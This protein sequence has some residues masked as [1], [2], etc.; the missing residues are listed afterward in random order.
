MALTRKSTRLSLALCLH[1]FNDL[2]SSDVRPANEPPV[3]WRCQSMRTIRK[4]GSH[5]LSILRLS[6]IFSPSSVHAG[7][8]KLSLAASPLTAMTFAPVAVLPILTM[9]I[10]FFAG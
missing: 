5:V 6:A 9:R 3:F 8:V 2:S 1:G 4:S 7:P 10:S